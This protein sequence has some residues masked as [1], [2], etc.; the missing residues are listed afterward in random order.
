[1]HVQN[2]FQQNQIIQKASLICFWINLF[3]DDRTADIIV[4]TS[5]AI[6][7]VP[8]GSRLAVLHFDH[9]PLLLEL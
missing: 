2:H 1:M 6:Y 4:G 3:L 7:C 8:R 5:K 9:V